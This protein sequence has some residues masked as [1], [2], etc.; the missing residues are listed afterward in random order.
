MQSF[1]EAPSSRFHCPGC[2]R[3]IDGAELQPGEQFKC[4]KCKKLMT[5]GPHLF[6]PRYGARWQ[7][8]RAVLLM[9]CIGSTVWCVTLGYGMGERTHRW[10]AAFGGS[11]AVWALVVGCIV[12]A[13][14]TVQSNG[15]LVGVTATM[16]G[17]ALFF[18]QRLGERLRYYEVS[19]WQQLEFYPLWA[20]ALIGVGLAVF[21][22]SLVVQ[23]RRR[24]L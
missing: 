6:D 16:A 17:V 2:G 14:R 22:A 21:V 15:V 24:S 8:G 12:L 18:I 1:F 23:A 9:A 4:A 3:V 10:V 11:L 13:A 20:P 19:G 5:F 7:T